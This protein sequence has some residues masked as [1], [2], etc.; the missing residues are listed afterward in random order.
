M[1]RG[2]GRFERCG[3]GAGGMVSVASEG[4]SVP[5]LSRSC[6]NCPLCAAQ[7]WAPCGHGADCSCS[8]V[9]GCCA[10]VCVCA[11]STCS[12]CGIFCVKVLLPALPGS[13]LI[14]I[15][16]LLR[17]CVSLRRQLARA[18]GCRKGQLC[19]LSGFSYSVRVP[20]LSL[21]ASTDSG[22]SGLHFA[23][24]Q[25][26]HLSACSFLAWCGMCSRC[27]VCH[28]FC[29]CRVLS[30][31]PLAAYCVRKYVCCYCCIR[32]VCHWVTGLVPA[33]E[34]CPALKENMSLLACKTRPSELHARPP[35]HTRQHL[36]CA[37]PAG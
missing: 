8:T 33:G 5:A 35:A 21:G 2:P 36:A 16:G 12:L 1:S 31:S 32:S 14:C 7:L 30:T 34:E 29:C 13:S 28:P 23:R 24:G 11:T 22:S 17:C 27:R 37:G 10:C 3:C 4:L 18:S 15:Q 19:P 26:W 6:G 25:G 20:A 9:Y